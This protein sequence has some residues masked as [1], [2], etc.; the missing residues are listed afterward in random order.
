MNNRGTTPFVSAV[1]VGLLGLLPA[2]YPARA[3]PPTGEGIYLTHCA[4]CHG[5]T[6]NGTFGPPLTGREFHQK[7]QQR[8]AQAMLKFV[9]T[10][11]PP[12]KPGSL[13]RDAYGEATNYILARNSLALLDA[14]SDAAQ[15]PAPATA[16]GS[17]AAGGAGNATE[18]EDAQFR[19][20]KARRAAVL[21]AMTPVTETMLRSP[22][23]DDWLSW[24]RTDDGFGYSPLVQINARNAADL[25]LAWSLSLPAGTNEITPL[26]HAGVLF[27]DSNGTVQ[28]LDAAN[29][30]LLWK[31]SRQSAPVTP[32]GPPVVQPRNMAIYGTT[33][34]VPTLD[35][36]LLALDAGTGKVIWDH[37]IEQTP[38]ILRLT[39]GPIVVR[40]K[41]IQGVSG[42]AGAGYPGGCFIVALDAQTGHEVWR[43]NTV[44]RP[45]QPGGDTWNDAPLSDRYGGSV[46]SAG[47]YDAELN[48][49]YFGTGQTY[50][51]TP[52]LRPKPIKPGSADALYTDTTLALDPDTGRLVW[53][54]Q[55]LAR[56]VWDLDWAFERT[57]LTLPKAYGTAKIVATMGKLGIVDA[58]DAKTGRY[59]FSHD[60][61]LQ[62]LVTAIDPRTGRK[63]IDPK[64]EPEAGKPKLICP[65][66]GG[67]RSWPATAYDPTTKTLFVP[68]TESCMLY[69]WK[70]GEEWDIQYTVVPR[71]DTDGKFSRVAAIN[72]ETKRTT[73]QQRRR[74]LQASAIAATAG[75][76]I[77]EGTR[78][79]W[80]R[81]SD[82]ATG[83][84]LWQARLD[85]TPNASPIVYGAGGTEYVSITTG[86]GG[87]VDVSSQS[88]T[89]EDVNPSGATTL[90]VFK[91]GHG[92]PSNHEQAR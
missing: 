77:F 8:G 87:P 72:L 53:H 40:G 90:W 61:G 44:A 67:V 26:V 73:W 80:F 35:N 54:Y 89:P 70:P 91:L 48:L 83:D 37:L 2:V 34:F 31:F 39:S 63:T 62:T 92:V 68:M 22:A 41:V 84:V 10:T 12:A 88:L 64:L 14:E 86:G 17:T 45:G 42:C 3:E 32:A 74:A 75:G 50:H 55:H 81:A 18:N 82:S 78:D 52:L 79:R 33:L 49:V 4:A 30:D 15:L 6:L 19:I 59:L 47:T 24:R 71:P 11:M 16:E 20:A 43:F 56:D 25:Q 51:V 60:P 85:L 29:G 46:W 28:A 36:H 27:V 76:V 66:P 21:A 65:F 9:S 7:W 57:I 1:A 5:A 58:L 38:G 69:V 13:A 23:N